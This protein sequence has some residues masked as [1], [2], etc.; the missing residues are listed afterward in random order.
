MP[1]RMQFCSMSQQLLLI[2]LPLLGQC[3]AKLQMPVRA[4]NSSSDSL[5]LFDAKP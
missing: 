4:V 1:C 2:P 3:H 5:D